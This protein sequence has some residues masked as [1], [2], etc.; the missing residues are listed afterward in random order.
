MVEEAASLRVQSSNGIRVFRTEFKIENVKILDDSFL[1]NGFRNYNHSTLDKPAQNDLGN[2]LVLFASKRNEEFVL[3]SERS[4][5]FGPAT[6]RAR[7]GPLS[8]RSALRCGEPAQLSFSYLPPIIE[9]M[10]RSAV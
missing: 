4:T 2:G 8:P 5:A 10:E 9:S 1:V 7:S 6:R 3:E